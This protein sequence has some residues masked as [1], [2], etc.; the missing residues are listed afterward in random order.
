MSETINFDDVVEKLE[1]DGIMQEPDANWIIEYIASEYGGSLDT[2]SDFVDNRYDLKIYSE[3][4]SDGYDI[5]WC[6]I[7]DRPYVCQDGFYYEDYET[8]SEQAVEHMTQGGNVWVESHI[9]DDMESDFNLELE[10]WWSDVYDDLHSEK[11]DELIDD[12]YEYE[13]E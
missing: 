11:V 5:F 7:D 1:A 9:W 4:T 13:D 12:G 3:S 8:W 10:Q 6:T 2:T